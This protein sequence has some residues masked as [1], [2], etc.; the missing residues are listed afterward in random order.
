MTAW[1]QAAVE[2]LSWWSQGMSIRIPRLIK[3]AFWVHRPAV[4]LSIEGQQA[5]VF[6]AGGQRPIHPAAHLGIG[7]GIKVAVA[8][9]EGRTI[10]IE[11]RLPLSSVFVRTVML[12]ASARK[13]FAQMLALDLSLSTPF[14]AGDIYTAHR[15][16][17]SAGGGATAKQVA[18][19]QLV[20]KRTIVDPIIERVKSA[21][22]SVAALTCPDATDGTAPPV[23]LWTDERMPYGRPRVVLAA[24]ATIALTFAT[25]TAAALV[26]RHDERLAQVRV[27]L[28]KERQAAQIV[29]QRLERA[30]LTIDQYAHLR[31]LKERRASSAQVIEQLSRI[32]PST[33]HLTELRI[34]GDVLDMSGVAHTAAQLPQ[35][36]ESSGMFVEAS[37]TSPLTLDGQDEGQ[38]FGLRARF[39]SGASAN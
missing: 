3:S 33:A 12:P 21:G 8:S 22:G 32:L 26:Y 30:Q 25:L 10:P 2:F 6:V 16:L 36:L 38:R 34:D 20:V 5:Y 24:Y 35:L 14:R 7:E 15:A 27:A 4:V 29:Q 13:Q 28:A 11:L 17:P 18:I 37:L 39:R 1:Q 31:R 19:Q 9:A 23:L